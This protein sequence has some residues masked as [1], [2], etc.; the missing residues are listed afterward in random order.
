MANYDR[1][2][3]LVGRTGRMACRAPRTGV[4][5]TP[6]TH[7]SLDERFLNLAI[8][9]R[10][11]MIGIVIRKDV[12]LVPVARPGRIDCRAPLPIERE[13]RNLRHDRK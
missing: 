5:G 12:R 1:P 4:V 9:R 13:I 3:C 7:R 10:S 8:L 11:G 2:R 6:A